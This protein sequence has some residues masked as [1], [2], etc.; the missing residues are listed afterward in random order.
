[1]SPKHKL[2]AVVDLVH[3]AYAL[4]GDVREDMSQK[5]L[6]NLDY[7]RASLDNVGCLV[8]QIT[9]SN[10]LDDTLVSLERK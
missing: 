9:E 10:Y 5:Q 3:L 7:C 4:L 8:T 6:A 1:M 2:V